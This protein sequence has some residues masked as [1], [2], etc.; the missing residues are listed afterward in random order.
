MK[1]HDIA[2]TVSQELAEVLGE[3]DESNVAEFIEAIL[4][5]KKIQVF[6]MGRMGCAANAFAMRLMHLG[7]EAYVVYETNTPNIGEGDLLVINCGCTTIGLE[8]ARLAKKTRASIALITAHPDSEVGKLADV[9]V[10]LRGQV[11]E[12]AEDEHPS[13]QPMA[14]LFE[15]SLFIFCDLVILLLMDRL[16]STSSDMAKRHTNLDGYM[17]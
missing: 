14:A 12:G 4:K 1:Y 16:K 2:S 3:V 11:H 17:G 15:Q 9:I 8:V 10:K 13:I 5:A 6:G 7:L